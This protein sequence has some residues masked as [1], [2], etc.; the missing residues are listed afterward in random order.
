MY[1]SF[2]QGNC[3]QVDTTSLW[4]ARAST[5][6]VLRDFLLSTSNTASLSNLPPPSRK[7]TT[8][9]WEVRNCHGVRIVHEKSFMSIFFTPFLNVWTATGC[10]SVVHDACEDPRLLHEA[11]CVMHFIYNTRNYR[12][13]CL[14]C[15]VRRTICLCSR[16]TW[17][18]LGSCIA[19][20]F[21]HSAVKYWKICL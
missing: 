14:H 1:W 10:H 20:S 17:Q 3:T 16:W 12:H 15:Q 5:Q 19:F 2:I 18:S 6:C 13:L 7:L 8:A 11:P 4:A 21:C 9:P